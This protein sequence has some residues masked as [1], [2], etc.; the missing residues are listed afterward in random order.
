MWN[1][2][3]EWQP[4]TAWVWD[5]GILSFQDYRALVGFVS[6][7]PQHYVIDRDGNIRWAFIGGIS[8]NKYYITQVVDEL[9]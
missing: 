1:D 5:R 7:V 6:G 3:P 8:T 4:S 2:H 9:I